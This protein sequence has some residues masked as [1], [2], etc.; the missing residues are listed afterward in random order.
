MRL[1]KIYQVLFL[2]NYGVIKGKL[3]VKYNHV[4]TSPVTGTVTFHCVIVFDLPERVSHTI[5]FRYLGVLLRCLYPCFASD[6]TTSLSGVRVMSDP[7]T[8]P[9]PG[10]EKM[11]LMSYANNEGADQTAHPRSLICAFVVRCLDS[12][13]PLDSIAEISRL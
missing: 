11:C 5:G 13:I 2:P 6:K 3:I 1:S 9:E 8:K 12:I 7:A 4:P 10:H